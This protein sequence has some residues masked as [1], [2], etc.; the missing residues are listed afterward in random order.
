MSERE[1]Q[2]VDQEA[3]QCLKQSD[4]TI[5]Q[6]QAKLADQTPM[7]QTAQLLDHRSR[8]LLY[9]VDVYARIS[10]SYFKQKSDR[11][12]NALEERQ[13]YT[14]AHTQI[15][16]DQRSRLPQDSPS[17]HK[18]TPS[19]DS[20]SNHSPRQR[21]SPAQSPQSNQ[22]SSKDS[23]SSPA[24][25]TA[26]IPLP[27]RKKN[28]PSS[29]YDD[30]PQFEGTDAAGKNH[31][32]HRAVADNLDSGMSAQLQDQLRKENIV[33][34]AS[35]VNMSD[36][37]RQVEQQ[38]IVISQAQQLIAH[39]LMQQR[40]DLEHIHKQTKDAAVHIKKGNTELEKAAQSGSKFRIFVLIFLLTMSFLLLVLHR[41]EA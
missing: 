14:K 29:I 22:N 30:D 28:G 7:R 8:V 40:D 3:D 32:D 39:N 38:I 37:I 1:R 36:D 2:K 10:Q 15:L 27:P 17:L 18:P 23:S 26:T 24:L 12:A 35:L 6:L 41:I 21:D 11:L 25:S 33:L 9:L 16:L 31:F 20:S 5:R 19:S 34:Q 4:S 13:G